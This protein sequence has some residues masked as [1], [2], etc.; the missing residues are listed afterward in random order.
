M[1]NNKI[2]V[3]VYCGVFSRA[4]GGVFYSIKNICSSNA[5]LLSFTLFGGQDINS[6]QDLVNLNNVDKKLFWKKFPK[7]YGFLPKAYSVLRH[8]KPEI[9]HIHG[10]WQ[11]GSLLALIC[12]SKS[13]I[14][15]S[16]HG[17]LDSW[18]L[19][20]SRMKKILL[21][22][23]IERTLM[24]KSS[25]IHALCY[26]EYISIR[27]LGLK[28]PVAIIP[29]GVDLPSMNVRFSVPSQRFDFLKNDQKIIL[30]FGRIDAKKGVHLLLES[31]LKLCGSYFDQPFNWKLVIAGWGDQ[32]YI[33]SLSAM[34]VNDINA[35]FVQFVGPCF[36]SDKE[37]LFRRSTA[38]VLPS[39]SEGLPM[40]VLE[41]WSFCL[42]VLITKECNL[43]EG[44]SND[45]AIEIGLSLEGVFDG[46]SWLVNANPCELQRIGQNGRN[47]VVQN[48]S[49]RIVSEKFLRL[50]RWID[51]GGVLPE[52][53]KI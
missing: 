25:C 41:A 18:A 3:F 14:L 15:V 8:F 49:S 17:M 16:P 52:F 5:K 48:Y 38:L 43:P 29:N 10:L 40:V 26:S 34:A 21:F 13:K 53:I 36:D 31:W 1:K 42:P 12:G 37:F 35:S 44:Y 6:T 19:K 9:I 32:D 39:Y 2:S 47:L 23:L 11:Y 27:N 4:A 33:D 28:N 7:R 30:Y 20:K 22:I 46:L 50:Y 51:A 24:R 45:A